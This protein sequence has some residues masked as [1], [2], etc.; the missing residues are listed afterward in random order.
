VNAKVL[1]PV[2]KFSIEIS[3]IISLE[4]SLIRCDV[5]G[6]VEYHFRFLFFIIEGVAPVIIDFTKNVNIIFFPMIVV[7][8]TD[9][10]LYSEQ[11]IFFQR[12][13]PFCNPAF[14]PSAHPAAP[15]IPGIPGKT[16]PA[17]R[18]VLTDRLRSAQR[19]PRCA[20]KPDQWCAV[21]ECDF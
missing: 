8:H 2:R 3:L 16:T 14:F 10:S 11:P 4:N 9:D 5:F 19:Y 12:F 1:N 13:C 7:I 17:L 20:G 6:Q 21:Y 15:R 18:K